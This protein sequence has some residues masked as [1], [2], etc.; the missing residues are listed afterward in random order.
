[1]EITDYM[2]IKLVAV[3]VIAFLAGLMGFLRK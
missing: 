1:M 2:W 3:A